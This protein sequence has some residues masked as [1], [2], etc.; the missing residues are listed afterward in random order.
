MK[1]FGI[2]GIL[3]LVLGT[4]ALAADWP[5]FRGNR[6][7]TGV[8]QGK[9]PDKL[10]LQWKFKIGKPVMATAVSGGGRVFLGADDGKF[11]CLNLSNGEKIW[12]FTSKDP[13]EAPNG[14]CHYRRQ[15]I[16]RSL[17]HYSKNV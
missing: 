2:S 3:G 5:I 13:F 12:E 1:Q 9:L 7:L 16:E 15:L 14:N 8:A 17:T 11:Y 10:H 6:G 4:G